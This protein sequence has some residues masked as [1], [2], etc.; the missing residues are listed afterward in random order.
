MPAPPGG[1][2]ADLDPA[3]DDRPPNAG[4]D[5]GS[6]TGG[7]EPSTC[8][9]DATMD[10]AAMGFGPAP[11]DWTVTITRPGKPLPIVI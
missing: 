5:V 10:G 8:S 7:P 4:V 1:Q 6:T 3:A 2:L 9:F 11:G